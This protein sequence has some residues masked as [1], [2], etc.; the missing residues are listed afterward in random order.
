MW[1]MNYTIIA[2]LHRIPGILET[3]HRMTDRPDLYSEEQCYNY[4]RDVPVKIMHKTGIITT[5]AFGEENLPAEGGYVLYPNHQGKFDAYT[6]IQAHK[7]SMTAVMDREKSY[8]VIVNEVM[9]ILRGKRLDLKDTRQALKIMNQIA[10]EVSEGRRYT[11]F[12]EGGYDD[13]KHNQLWDF[14]P[15]CFKAATKAKAPIVPVA[16]V[17]SYKPYNS[18]SFAPVKIQ[19]HFL[20]PLYYEDY[21]ELNTTQI[22]AIV[23][24]RIRNKLTELGC[25]V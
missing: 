20:E 24:D 14:K 16:M 7:K 19:V 4:V 17:D 11:I 23:K 18:W 22:S 2:N 3:M 25:K 15:G 12:P 5:H 1:R 6:L 21:K 8:S 13:N 9:E 10:Q